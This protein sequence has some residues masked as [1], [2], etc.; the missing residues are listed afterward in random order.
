M[1]NLWEDKINY[2]ISLANTYQVKMIMVGA[3][4]GIAQQLQEINI[5]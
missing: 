5:K 4:A 1:N 3:G 2:F